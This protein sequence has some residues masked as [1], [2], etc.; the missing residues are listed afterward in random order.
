MTPMSEVYTLPIDTVLNYE[1]VER[2]LTKGFTRMPVSAT[3]DK[4]RGLTCFFCFVCCAF[5]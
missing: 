1:I 3:G 4:V 5:S 2:L